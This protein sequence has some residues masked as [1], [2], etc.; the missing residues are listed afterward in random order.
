MLALNSP[1]SDVFAT[2]RYKFV[3][4]NRAEFNSKNVEIADLFCQ[5]SRFTSGLYVRDVEY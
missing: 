4:F 2:A 3:S 5:K 1:E